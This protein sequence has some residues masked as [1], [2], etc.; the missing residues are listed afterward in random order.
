MRLVAAR[1]PMVILWSRLHSHTVWSTRMAYEYGCMRLRS[2]SLVVWNRCDT[3]RSVFV[4]DVQKFQMSR[5]FLAKRSCRRGQP[6]S[7]GDKILLRST[8][9]TTVRTI[10]FLRPHLSASAHDGLSSAA[11]SSSCSKQGMVHNVRKRTS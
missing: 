1:V 4:F 2:S 9:G 5:S 3:F 10:V 7:H 11:W 8:S 6:Y